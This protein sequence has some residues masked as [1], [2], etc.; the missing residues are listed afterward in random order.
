[1]AATEA[2]AVAVRV[3]GPDD[4]ARLLPLFER[5]YH[6]EGFPEAVAGV[7]DN[8]RQVLAREDTAAFI[9]LAGEEA[10]GA[11]AASTSFGLEVGLYAELEDLFVEPAWR[12]GGVASALVEAAADWARSKG[13]SDMEI[14][15]TPHAQAKADLAPWSKARGF[16]DTG[17][18]IYER[19]L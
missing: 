7:A 5:F 11:A 2:T 18:V 12:R 1:M 19:S 3:A 14:V 9:A 8:L 16:V 13:C 17:R 6:E 10:V 4:L 15:L